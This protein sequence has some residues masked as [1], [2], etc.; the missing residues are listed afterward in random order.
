MSVYIYRLSQWI[1]K[2]FNAK[3]GNV[4]TD[5]DQIAR[6]IVPWQVGVEERYLQSWNRYAVVV[7][8]AAVA[9]NNSR[10][11]IRN[12]VGSN[13]IIVIEKIDYFNFTGADSALVTWGAVTTDL[14]SLVTVTFTRMDPRGNPQPTAIVSQAAQ[15]AGG[16]AFLQ[17]GASG[18][19]VNFS[20]IQNP[21]QQITVL[22]GQA[23]DVQASTVNTSMVISFMWR[24][25]ALELSELT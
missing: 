25:R 1:E 24:E 19:N 2:R 9:A 13:V 15:A 12:P 17:G 14:T 18:T 20:F 23:V 4:I 10:A 11:R 5:I 22:P 8:Q 7:N 6:A 16:Q 21:D 3:G